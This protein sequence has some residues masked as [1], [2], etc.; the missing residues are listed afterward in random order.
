MVAKIL[1]ELVRFAKKN[2]LKHVKCGDI[3][4]TF[5]EKQPKTVKEKE[6][7][8]EPVKIKDMVGDMPNDDDLM[9]WSTGA[10]LS[11]EKP[12]EE[13]NVNGL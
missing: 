3:E 4:F 8:L 9:L 2:N 13:V 10:Q 7:E 11:F 12:K 5:D 1:K 6:Q